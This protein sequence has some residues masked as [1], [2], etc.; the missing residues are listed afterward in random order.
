MTVKTRPN[1]KVKKVKTKITDTNNY[2]KKGVMP[3]VVYGSGKYDIP[4]KKEKAK[5]KKKDG[6][7]KKTKTVNYGPAAYN[8]KQTKTRTKKTY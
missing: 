6:M 2:S 8:G 5:F 3:G 1:G 4:L 7:L